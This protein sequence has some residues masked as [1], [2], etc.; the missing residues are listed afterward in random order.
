MILLSCLNYGMKKPGKI[1]KSLLLGKIISGPT[2]IK[3]SELIKNNQIYLNYL[4]DKKENRSLEFLYKLASDS[5]K[6]FTELSKNKNFNLKNSGSLQIFRSKKSFIKAEKFCSKRS[7]SKIISKEELANFSISD[8][9][10]Y[11][12]IY[13]KGDMRA[14]CRKFS[15]SLI[16]ELKKN[17]HFKLY[18]NCKIINLNQGKNKI[19]KIITNKKDFSGKFVITSGAYL[20]DFNL[21]LKTKLPFFAVK[22]YSAN[23]NNIKISSNIIDHDKKM[24]YTNLGNHSRIAG[25]YDLHGLDLSTQEKRINLFKANIENL[26]PKQKI[27]LESIWAGVRCFSSNKYPN[28]SKSLNI[29]NLYFNSGHANLGWTLS[30]ASGK[31]LAEIIT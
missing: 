31:Y 7:D 12:G 13:F 5:E 26:F 25:L 14:D 17:P 28:I 10:I 6:I 11:K 24:V 27:E 30:A 1:I 21:L 8:S 22:G 20:T 18:K 15:L 4:R 23:C 2:D 29:D 19:E 16:S 9:G 3:F